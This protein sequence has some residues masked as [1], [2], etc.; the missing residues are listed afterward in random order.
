MRRC[1]LLLTGLTLAGC[2]RGGPP[3]AGLVRGTV[4]F[5]GRPLA[6]GLVVLVP[7]RDKGTGG[8]P[9]R[10]PIADDG[11]YEAEGVPAGWY[12]VA[13]ADPPGV[14][15]EGHGWPRF[16]AALRRPDRAGLEREVL[17]G[18]TNEL[19]FHIEAGD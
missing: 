4:T 16:P 13:L 1:A 5:Q 8:K 7:D 9:V 2:G 14:D 3:P 12:R 19:H 11:S 18:R 17:G 6:G 15:W 10:A